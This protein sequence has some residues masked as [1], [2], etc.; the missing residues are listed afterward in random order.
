METRHGSG[1]QRCRFCEDFRFMREI[2]RE[3]EE[4]VNKA[5]QLYTIDHEY[6]VRLLVRTLRIWKDDRTPRKNHAG[7]YTTEGYK[8]RFCPECGK[9]IQGRGK[10]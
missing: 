9:R 3:T 8:L 5:G 7:D 10:R 4:K 6:K 2:D 1:E